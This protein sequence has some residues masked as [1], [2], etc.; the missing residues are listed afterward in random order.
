MLKHRTGYAWISFGLV[1]LLRLLIATPAFAQTP[2]PVIIRVNPEQAQ[3]AVGQTVDVSI[4]V[5]NVTDLYA[6]DV[7]LAY[8]PQAVEVIDLDPTLEGVQVGLGTFLEPGFVIL[9]LVDNNLGRLRLAMTQ[10]NPATPK[11]GDG[12]LIVLRLR[13]KTTRAPTPIEVLTVKLASPAGVEIAVGS[14]ENGGIEVIQTMPAATS[15]S[16]PFQNPGTPMPT[17]KPP[18]ALPTSQGQSVTNPTFPAQPTQDYLNPPATATSPVLPSPTPSVTA[19]EAQP[20]VSPTEPVAPQASVT[21][22]ADTDQT[23]AID[24]AISGP[25]ATPAAQPEAAPAAGQS[26][27]SNAWWM[28]LIAGVFLA[29][30]T[31]IYFIWHRKPPEEP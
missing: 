15:T 10:L 4:E 30:G 7:L 18:T 13:G 27:T 1:C 26:T 12:A 22:P 2:S 5:Q 23:N 8:D 19:T 28:I 17:Q 9:N 14:I 29:G 20:V 31:A 25:T 16:I 3:M 6:I 24:Q 21:T 11:S